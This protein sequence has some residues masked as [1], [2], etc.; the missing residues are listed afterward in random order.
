MSKGKLISS[1]HLYF[2]LFKEEDFP[3]RYRERL[4]G[5]DVT[6]EEA[7]SALDKNEDGEVLKVRIYISERFIFF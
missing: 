2:H 3:Q 1:H 5:K 4:F 6:V 7:M